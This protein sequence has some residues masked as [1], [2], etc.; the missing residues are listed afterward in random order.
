MAFRCPFSGSCT[1]DE[2]WQEQL[3][4]Q[5]LCEVQQTGGRQQEE[6]QAVQG[7]VRLQEVGPQ[8]PLPARVQRL[9][10]P[11]G[12]VLQAPQELEACVLLRWVSSFDGDHA[13]CVM[14]L[15]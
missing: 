5:E 14:V 4:Q 10:T 3:V 11:V 1:G 15:A 12:K 2:A 7:Q 13:A 8:E 6:V 9:R